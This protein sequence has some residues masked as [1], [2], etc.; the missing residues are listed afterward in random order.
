MKRCNPTGGRTQV[1]I[2][3]KGVPADFG[4]SDEGEFF[5][6]FDKNKAAQFTNT[7]GDIQ[8]DIRY[9]IMNAMSDD[10]S[11]NEMWYQRG[12]AGQG[13]NTNNEGSSGSTNFLNLLPPLPPS[14]Y[15]GLNSNTTVYEPQR[16]TNH[17]Q[18]QVTVNPCS[19]DGSHQF[20]MKMRLKPFRI[21][22]G[23]RSTRT[24]NGDSSDF[25]THNC[26]TNDFIEFNKSA[27]E[28]IPDAPATSPTSKSPKAD[29][30][31]TNQGKAT[32]KATR[33][34]GE[35]RD[36]RSRRTKR[37]STIEA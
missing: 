12:F 8:V 37:A 6:C 13:P 9:K 5:D 28:G 4:L 31:P 33:N 29:K 11:S 35:G 15:D 2:E 3:C 19:T 10:Y 21:N 34:T 18:R 27:D 25:T 20:Y 32:G 14:N 7:C 17:W 16:S 24:I 26:G 23:N 1:R 22:N 36:T 30:S